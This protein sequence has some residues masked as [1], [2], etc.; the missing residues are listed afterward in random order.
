MCD[1]NDSQNHYPYWEVYS[2]AG[3][4]ITTRTEVDKFTQGGYF[5]KLFMEEDFF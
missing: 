1:E 5:W 2:G 3:N 4:A